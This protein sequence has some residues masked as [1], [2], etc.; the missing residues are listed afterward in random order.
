MN[1]RFLLGVTCGAAFAVAAVLACGDDSPGSADAAVDGGQC[2]CPASEPPLVNRIVRVTSNRGEILPIN[3]G[4]AATACAQGAILLGGGCSLV[5]LN[6][7][8]KVQLIHNGPPVDGDPNAW[9]CRW[10]NAGTASVTGVATV[11]CYVPPK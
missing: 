11:N 9:V 4:G 1:R 7:I 3:T 5:D 10:F 8:A 6:D 2:E